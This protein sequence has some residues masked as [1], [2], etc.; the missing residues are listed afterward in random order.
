MTCV[1][2]EF[3]W[4]PTILTVPSS[5]YFIKECGVGC[6][7]TRK[8]L[9]IFTSCHAS[10]ENTA[11]SSTRILKFASFV[12]VSVNLC[13]FQ[14]FVR[15][16]LDW[17]HLLTWCLILFPNKNYIEFYLNH[18]W[19]LLPF[20]RSYKIYRY[21]NLPKRLVVEVTRK[22]VLNFHLNFKTCSFSTRCYRL[23]LRLL[24]CVRKK[25][26]IYELCSKQMF[27]YLDCT[28]IC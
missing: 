12:L 11:M 19:M 23:S 5:I 10:G 17:C 27:K 25:S 24:F 15:V 6:F 4:P 7:K 16:S 20:Q 3:P 9:L 13:Y 8:R 26:A 14:S 28:I 2:K 22:F 1:T 18:C 21:S